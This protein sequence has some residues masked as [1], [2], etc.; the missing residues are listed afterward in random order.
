MN[1]F[2]LR[3]LFQNIPNY[4]ILIFGIVFV[5]VMLCFAFGLPDSLNNYG[6]RAPDMLFAQYQYVL[7]NTKDDDGNEL[8]TSNADA[9]KFNETSLLYEKN[10]RSFVKGRGSGGSTESV[11]VYGI[12][13]GSKYVHI[14]EELE[15]GNVY[16][17][18]AVS[19]KFGF[20]E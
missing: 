14:D 3:I 19:D 20:K 16:I 4:V 9:E 6:D 11:A 15:A 2:R 7:V 17:S 8:V 12:E 5:E 18:S 13:D 1:R 10:I